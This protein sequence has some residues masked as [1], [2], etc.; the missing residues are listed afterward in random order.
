MANIVIID[1]HPAIRM[2]VCIL[3]EN[4]G[5]CIC[6][7]FNNSVDALALISKKP[8]DILVLDINLPQINGF[9]IIK[10]C[11]ELSSPPKIV[12]FSAH[13]S[14]HIKIRCVQLGVAAFVSKVDDL[15]KLS[16]VIEHVLTG[17][18]V[19]ERSIHYRVIN[20]SSVCDYDALEKLSSREISVLMALTRGNTNKKIANDLTLSEK[21]I[22]TYKKRLM[23]KLNIKNIVELL[24]FA[25]Y[26]NLG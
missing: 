2:A 7:E 10:R 15:T 19:L 20:N 26:H 22:S 1:D 4:N 12:V 8:P 9:D 3:L 11:N 14:D 16:E 23:V 13:D 24:D 17:Y 5:H 25:K 21:T 18:I 6:G